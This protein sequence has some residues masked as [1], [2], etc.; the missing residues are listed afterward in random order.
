MWTSCCADT[1]LV[2][3]SL[4]WSWLLQLLRI[5]TLFYRLDLPRDVVTNRRFCLCFDLLAFN[6]TVQYWF[7]SLPRCF[8]ALSPLR[9]AHLPQRRPFLLFCWVSA[10]PALF[11]RCAALL[12][13]SA[14]PCLFSIAQSSL[15]V[16][17]SAAFLT[18]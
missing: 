8:F 12:C 14:L 4:G 6:S 11:L 1:F 2:C 10:M 5:S 16:C 17:C 15:R 3:W 18:Y 9:S 13:R 7:L